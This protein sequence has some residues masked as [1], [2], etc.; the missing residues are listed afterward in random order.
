MQIEPSVQ[1]SFEATASNERVSQCINDYFLNN[2]L[3]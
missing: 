1:F 2:F 3:C